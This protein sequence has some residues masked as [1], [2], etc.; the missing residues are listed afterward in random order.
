MVTRFSAS[1][2]RLK[3]DRA[4]K[5][6]GEL[7][8]RNDE[9]KKT[10]AKE[11]SIL[12]AGFDKQ[13]SQIIFAAIDGKKELQVDA[14]YLYQDLI[15]A[16]V[17]VLE[18][19]KVKQQFNANNNIE[20]YD[21]KEELKKQVLEEFDNFID[22]SKNDL[23]EYYGSLKRFHK[24]NYDAVYDVLNSSEGTRYSGDDIFFSE[25]PT[26]LK[27]KYYSRIEKINKII[28]EYKRCTYGFDFGFYSNSKTDEEL[29]EGEYFFGADDEEVGVLKPTSEGNILKISWTSEAGDTHMNKPLLSADGLA[30]LSSYRGQNLIEEVFEAL[31]SAA[32]NGKSTHKLEFS[33]VKDGW[34]FV[35]SSRKIYS[36]QPNQLAEIIQREGFT[37]Q[38]ETATLKNYSIKVSW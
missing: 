29:I 22:E 1:E 12:K 13:Q 34:L 2:A 10:L 27:S 33:S 35:T 3:A 36:C 6:L 31:S 25:V 37:V 14:V 38:S 23:K 7:K 30:W 26:Y 18:V 8:I 19:G 5:T 15:K 24:L 21:E 9:I 4:K 28:R 20:D 32:S 16:G 17:S 11:R